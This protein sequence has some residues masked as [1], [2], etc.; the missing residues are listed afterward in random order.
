MSE[1]CPASRFMAVT[2]WPSSTTGLARA[3]PS[4]RQL[5][6]KLPV[7]SPAI[8][9]M[10]APISDGPIIRITSPVTSGGKKRSTIENGFATSRPKMPE[11]MSAP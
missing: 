6:E 11:M 3:G 8:R 10:S 9:P 2:T 7:L 5:R 1:I 4:D